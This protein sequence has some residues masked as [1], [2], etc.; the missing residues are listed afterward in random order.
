MCSSPPRNPTRSPLCVHI[1]EAACRGC[2]LLSAGDQGARS[3]R[4]GVNT[5]TFSAV[6]LLE[7][8]D[9]LGAS[10]RESEGGKGDV[11]WRVCR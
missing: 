6:I 10:A 8:G 7:D 3:N 1:R 9:G 4:R 2:S 5:L 11:Q